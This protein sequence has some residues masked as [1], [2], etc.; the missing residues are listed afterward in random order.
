MAPVALVRQSYRQVWETLKSLPQRPQIFKFLIGFYLISD[1]IVTLNNFLGIYLTTQ[2]GLTFAEILQY[3]LLFN[4]VSIPAT[5]LFGFL[6]DRLSAHQ[7]LYSLLL[8]WGIAV[9]IMVFST[10]PATSLV[11][12][13]LLGLIFGSTQAFCRGWFASLV[14]VNQ[15]TELFGFNALAGRLASLVG[16]LLFGVISSLSGNQ[17]L[18]MASLVLFLGLGAFILS[19]VPNP[20]K[21]D[22][23]T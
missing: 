7:V 14:Q 9:T 12:A 16:P 1:A 2:F 22:W 18:A 8:L 6:G 13:I 15:A 21:V 20:R 17:R 3:G 19:Q 11:L 5:I 10:N 4:L 23:F